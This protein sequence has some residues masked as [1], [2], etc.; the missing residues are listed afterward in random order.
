MDKIRWGI[1][2]CGDVTE[3][4]S[5][6]AFQKIDNSDLIA[7]TSRN[8]HKAKDYAFRHNVSKWYSDPD[9]LIR[10]SEI[11]AVYIATPPDSHKQYTIK[12][13]EAGKSV[14]VEKPMARCHQECLEMI[15]SC[16]TNKVKLFTAYYRRSLP[17]FIK[18]KELIESGRLGDIRTILNLLYIPFK[19]LHTDSKNL[20]W[21]VKPEISGGGY[22]VD[23][24]SHTIDILQFILG[25]IIHTNGTA[26]NQANLYPAEDTVSANFIFE[27][28]IT[29]I[30]IWCFTTN[31]HQDFIKILYCVV[32]SSL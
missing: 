30:G 26:V 29:G 5:G 22:F 28:G 21:R 12:V 23:L 11:D 14:Y 2:G 7:V 15:S 20:P 13:A 17:K 19:N 24:A 8:E 25:S 9:L 3:V 18:V 27:G 10:D 31:N 16:R 32:S 6:P 4:K 1:I